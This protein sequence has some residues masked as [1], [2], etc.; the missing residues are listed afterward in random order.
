MDFHN[1][2]QPDQGEES[3]TESSQRDPSIPSPFFHFHF[4]LESGVSP[5]NLKSERF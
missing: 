5:E 1:D 3:W 4:S 2:E